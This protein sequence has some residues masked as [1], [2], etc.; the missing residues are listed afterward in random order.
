MQILSE[1]HDSVVFMQGTWKGRLSNT[2]L[3]ELHSPLVKRI[4][5][6][7]ETFYSNSMFIDCQQ[8]EKQMGTDISAKNSICTDIKGKP[9]IYFFNYKLSKSLRTHL[10]KK[11]FRLPKY[12]LLIYNDIFMDPIINFF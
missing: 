9:I 6:P 2:Y 7:Y 3:P 12:K 8:L 1:R 4:D 11:L 10:T 5:A